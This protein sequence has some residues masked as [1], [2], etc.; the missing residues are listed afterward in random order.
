MNIF[1][2]A[3]RISVKLRELAVLDTVQPV[4]DAARVSVKL[5][6]P[7]IINK[8]NATRVSVGIENGLWAAAVVLMQLA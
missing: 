5:R 3:T 6:E 4:D 7:V 2:D 1:A 8:R